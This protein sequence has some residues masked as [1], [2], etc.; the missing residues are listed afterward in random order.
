L[1]LSEYLKAVALFVLTLVLLGIGQV[2]PALMVGAAC[3]V[4][5]LDLLLE[6]L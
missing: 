6:I 5:S 4:I 1:V 2:V 3:V